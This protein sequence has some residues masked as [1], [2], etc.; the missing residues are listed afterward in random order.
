[1]S[2]R[3]IHFCI[4]EV[5]QSQTIVY[6]YF[7]YSYPN[8]IEIKNTLGMRKY[9]PWIRLLYVKYIMHLEYSRIL[10][11]L[12]EYSFLEYSW[13][14]G[15]WYSDLYSSKLFGVLFDLAF[16]HAISFNIWNINKKHTRIFIFP[17]K[18]M[19]QKPYTS[20]EYWKRLLE[21]GD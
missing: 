15:F 13:I 14:F 6:S 17:Q 21:T 5:C 7:Q 16:G 8:T 3:N 10:Q 20:K 1:M 9:S 2:R 11:I 19:N 12:T 18:I 4:P